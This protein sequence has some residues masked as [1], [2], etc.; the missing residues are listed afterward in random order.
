MMAGDPTDKNNAAETS[1]VKDKDRERKRSRSRERERKGSPSKDRKPRQRSRERNRSKS[2]ERD[3]RLKDKER[4]KEH[5]RDKNR[6][7]GRKDRDKDGH[8]RDKD[9]SKKSRSVSPKSKDRIKRE[10]D[11]KKE[12][13]EE[14]EKKK[15]SKVQPLSLEELLAKKKAEEEAEAKPKFL[16]KA[17]R[18]AEALKRR[19]QQTEERKKT[20]DEDRKKRRM[21]QDIGRKMMED[22][23]ERD[24]R[25]R[26]E[27]ME[28][29]NNGD[30]AD[31]GRQKI[32][33]EKDKGKELQAIKERYLGGT[34][35][36]RRTRHLNDRKFV[37]EWDASEDTSTDYNPIYKEKH[38]VQLYGRGFIAGIDLKQQ[39]KDQSHFYVDMM[40]TRR[41]LE[42]KEQEEVRLKKVH[43]KEAKQRWDDRHWS[44][45]KLE[46]MADRDW[47]IFREDYSITTK[48]GK[49]PHP[50][51]NWKEYNLPPHIVEVID[52]CGYKDPTPIQR[53]AIPIG[54]QN[55]D[56]IG[57]AETGSGKTAAFLI[58]L[59][60]WITTLPK[61]E[62]IEDSDQ[63]PY[64]VI[65][66]PTRE[67]A[68]Q[69]EEET[70]KFGKPLGIRTVAVIGGI[71][72]EDQGFR[73]RMGCEIV[74][75]TPG[76]L[77]DVLENRYLVLGRCTYVVL[78]E[79]DRMIDMGFEPDVQ[80]ILEYIP[81][82]NQ[83]P[84]TDEAED[85][86]KM[87][88]NFEMGKHK[89]RQTV[90]FTATMPAA[91]ERLARNYLRRPAVVYIGSAGKPHERVEQKVLLMGEGEK[92]KRLLDVLARGFEPPIIIF[93]NQKKGVDV[94]A[95]SLEKMGYNA[96]TLHGGKG[97]EQREFALSN[98]KAGAKDI[99]VATDV[100]G[101]GIDIHDVSMV[102]N[103]DMAKNIED[104]IHRIGRT[105]RAGK[106]G[107][108]LTFLTKE[109]S[110]VFYDLKQAFLESPVST[111]PP[112]LS[113]H[114]DAQHKPGTILTKKRREETIFA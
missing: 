1:G 65:L 88:M 54:L 94:L 50:I 106:S 22:P 79:A 37:F 24:R 19:Q 47:R 30:Q 96:C 40:E 2:A 104:Y 49:I 36:R 20:I 68:Q 63:G 23:Q 73:L 100:A 11:L 80:K 89:Y 105:G 111:C 97:Q 42:E 112:E 78:D 76:R 74:I 62:R 66:A 91:V 70:L 10:K 101:R 58:P 18:E 25:E 59:L 34:K 5:D 12:E 60:V 69:I 32:R 85:P 113:N 57:V 110:S 103:Y 14:D 13:D 61:D 33:E 45:K 26:R 41:T 98:L 38:Q 82:T 56:I 114:P 28:R 15:K 46:E 93:V 84:D 75:A 102:L 44:Q 95:K 3:R 43:K 29:E 108:A 83:K 86:E 99:L 55:R 6:E 87:K 7:R 51:R 35:K 27:R 109:D 52:N 92:R 81:V 8:R 16:S 48:G 90:M 71:S 67:L 107:V 31:D 64:A 9:C 21:F 4:E 17:E 77:I 72:R 53:Q 39:K